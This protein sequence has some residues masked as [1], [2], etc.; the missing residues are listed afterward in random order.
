M[1]AAS[2]LRPRLLQHGMAWHDL[3]FVSGIT[4]RESLA[5]ALPM[6]RSGFR[7]ILLLLL[8][9]LLSMLGA[10]CGQAAV[11][12]CT[13]CTC[14]LQPGGRKVLNS[15]TS[16]L[17]CSCTDQ[18]SQNGAVGWAAAVAPHGES[19]GWDETGWD[20]MGWMRQTHAGSKQTTTNNEQRTTNSEIQPRIEPNW[21]GGH[22][23]P[24]PTPTPTRWRAGRGSFV[25]L[26]Y[27]TVLLVLFV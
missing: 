9:L 17:S 26:Q 4:R 2:I 1:F 23:P 13:L 20:G 5:K 18:T 27:S 14:T 21:F 16:L 3:A 25:A 22:Q 11:S 15:S 24:T 19:M 10:Q 8:L 6:P 12:Y 7:L